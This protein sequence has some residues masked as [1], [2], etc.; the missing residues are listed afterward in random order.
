MDNTEL[1]HLMEEQLKLS[2]QLK[3]RIR[4]LEAA[5]TAPLAIVSTALRLPGGLS[6]PQDYWEFLLGD[7][8][9]ISEIPE[10]RPGLRSVFDPAPNT[11]NRWSGYR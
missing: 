1:L 5:R 3:A 11:P 4:E 9:V 7:R 2:K 10:D 8:D 6:T